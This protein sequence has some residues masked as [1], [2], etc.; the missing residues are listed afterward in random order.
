M[1]SLQGR[2]HGWLELRRPRNT[3]RCLRGQQH[4]GDPGPA[5]GQR[6]TDQVSGQLRQ[7][8]DAETYV[9]ITVKLGLIKLSHKQQLLSELLG[10]WGASVPTKTDPF[11]LELSRKLAKDTPRGKFTIPADG[12]TGADEDAFCLEFTTL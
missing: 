2:T 6:P 5:G 1:A 8:P 11:T 12:Y 10:E 9:D 3:G 7:V 4:R